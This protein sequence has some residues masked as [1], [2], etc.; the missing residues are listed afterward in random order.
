MIFKMLKKCYH[1]LAFL[2]AIPFL[3]MN[4]FTKYVYV[5]ELISLIPFRMGELIRYYFY[6]KTLAECGDNVVI[7][8]GSIISYPDA[9]VGNHVWIGTYNIFGHIDIGDFAQI[10]QG[11]HFLSGAHQY[12][13]DDVSKPIKCQPGH[14]KRIKIGPDIWVG[15]NSTVM[16]NIG[17]GC[18]IGSGSVITKDIPDYSVAAGNPARVIR[19]RIK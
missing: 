7:S 2:A 12:A 9:T 8:F 1:F 3:F 15:A 10:S 13:I 5:T 11:S 18:V 6:K 17:Y 4:K 16:A 19:S 14:P